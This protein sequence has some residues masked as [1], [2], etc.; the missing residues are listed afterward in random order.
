[1][2]IDRSRNVGVESDHYKHITDS[3]AQ[4]LFKNSASVFGLGH[5]TDESSNLSWA[6]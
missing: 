5:G 2:S 1:M 3:A 6:Q 4:N